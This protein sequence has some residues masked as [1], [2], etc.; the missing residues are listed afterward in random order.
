VSVIEN[1]LIYT[2]TGYPNDAYKYSAEYAKY[3]QSVNSSNRHTVT[4]TTVSQS[5]I[6]NKLKLT[7]NSIFVEVGANKVFAGI[8]ASSDYSMPNTITAVIT[9]Q[10][11]IG[12]N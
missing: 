6:I 7:N 5:D 12:I 3:T 9:T 11:I 8:I 10:E 1:G 4:A 2:Y